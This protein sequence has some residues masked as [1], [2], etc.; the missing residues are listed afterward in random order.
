M[1]TSTRALG[2]LKRVDLREFWR[3]E[4]REFTPWLASEQNLRLLGEAIGI[5]LEV[6]STETR[7]GA[8]KADIVAKEAGT[9]DRIIIENQLERTNHDHL[10]KLL[11]YASG[12]GAKT[13]VWVAA[14][15]SDEHRRAI[16]WLN[17]ITTDQY[18]FFGLEIELWRIGESEPAPKF[19]LVCQPNDWARTLTGGPEGAEPTET[20]LAQLEFWSALVEFAKPRN[21]GL[22]F[23]KPRPQHWY[24]ISIGRSHFHLSLTV[25]TKL[26]R[27]GCQLYMTSHP[28]SK[29]AFALLK[30]DQADIESILGP[31]EWRELTTKRACRIVAYRP[32]DIGDRGTWPELQGWLLDRAVAFQR[33]FGPRVRAL[34]LGEE[35]EEGA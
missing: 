16:D 17:E 6:E 31:L 34:D 27:V 25:N 11:T 8:F 23:Q 21:T 14:E 7:V 18:A 24:N 22:S 19:N 13:V 12:L 2:S 1:A 33:V 3:D 9:E 32:G 29:R 20:K 30:E 26:A 15:L 28:Q 35:E 5:D 10:G 4:A